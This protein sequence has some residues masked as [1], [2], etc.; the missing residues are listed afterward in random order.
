VE[1]GDKKT[2]VFEYYLPDDFY[3]NFK[4]SN[5]Y[6]LLLQKQP[7]NKVSQFEVY[8]KFSKPIISFKNDLGLGE[9]VNLNQEKNEIQWTDT[10][11][12]DHLLELKF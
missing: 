12:Q 11:K 10:L 1:P 6:S 7:G 5:S 2:L 8:L 9:A 4:R 3:Q